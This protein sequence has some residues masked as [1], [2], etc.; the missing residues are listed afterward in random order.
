[1]PL[2]AIE[3]PAPRVRPAGVARRTSSLANPTSASPTR[4]ARPTA[5]WSAAFAGRST[6]RRTWSRIRAT[7]ARSSRSS[8]GAPTKGLAAI[9]FGGGTSVVGGI[10]P[11]VGDAYRGAVTIDLGALDRVLEVDS[12]SRAARIQAGALGPSLEDQLREHGLHAAPLPPVVRVLH[13]RRAGSPPGPAA[14][15]R[16]STRTST[17]WSSRCGR[18]PR[19]ALWESRRLPGSGAG[20]SP[21]RLLL[22]SEGILGVITEAWVRVRERPRWK[23]SCGVAFDSFVERRRGGPRAGAVR[24]LSGQLPAAR[25][26]GVGAHPRRARP[27]RPCWSSAS[28][29]R[30][31]RS[32]CRWRSRSRR[33]APAAASRGR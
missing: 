12:V 22:G 5:T 2:E 25:R 27:V 1:M 29:R 18:S 20:P 4:S 23:L 15:S 24:A 10:E 7:S 19:A 9:P 14:T 31:I 32:T 26:G 33:P 28:S 8:R 11:R 21:D 16:R 30:T 17:T 3:L 6:T 13:A